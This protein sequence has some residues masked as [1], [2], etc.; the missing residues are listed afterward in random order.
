ML[1]LEEDR[2][3]ASREVDEGKEEHGRSDQIGQGA[4]QTRD[5]RCHA[6]DYQPEVRRAEPLLF[7]AEDLGEQS[8][9][10][11]RIGQPRGADGP[12]FIGSR[13]RQQRAHTDDQDDDGGQERGRTE[14]RP[15]R[16]DEGTARCAERA[17]A[18]GADDEEV[19]EEVESNH[20]HHAHEDRSRNRL[21]RLDHLIRRQGRELESRVGPEDEDERPTECGDIAGEERDEVP[22]EL[23]GL[24]RH[25]GKSSED[26]QQERRQLRDRQD[27]IDASSGLDSDEVRHQDDRDED[28]LQDRLAQVVDSRV[29]GQKVLG[30]GDRED[31]EGEPLREEETPS[32]DEPGKRTGD[33][34]HIGIGSADLRQDHHTIG[35]GEGDDHR[36][37]SCQDPHEQRR[38][39]HEPRPDRGGDIHVGPDDRADD[40]AG[41]VERVQLGRHAGLCAVTARPHRAA[42]APGLNTGLR[43]NRRRPYCVRLE[44]EDCPVAPSSPAENLATLGCPP[45]YKLVPCHG[46]N[47]IP[48]PFLPLVITKDF[49]LTKY[50]KRASRGQSFYMANSF[51]DNSEGVASTV[52]TLFALL[53]AVLFLQAALISLLPARQY[54]AERQTS[55]AA[56]QALEYL[57]YAAVGAAVPGVQFSFT[58]PLG[59]PSSSAFS[60]P[61]DGT[62]PFHTRN[63]AAA[64][65]TMQYVPTL[66]D[67]PINQ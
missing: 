46:W 52:A 37:R 33:R 20:D 27:V 58:I 48:E 40:E 9:N 41:H 50:L 49:E 28:G 36:D 47:R 57:R 42:M 30:E 25:E 18:D 62:L 1:A 6:E 24:K 35:E 19:R 21:P 55:V 60:T 2:G 23:A 22:R 29:E 4:H 31:R 12:R 13:D 66:H 3:E 17:S 43:V 7:P 11:H 16:V 67:N 56:L 39:A 65:I 64:D 5:V 54:A 14:R 38:R 44:V 15:S 10:R 8:V 45:P 61:S 26:D 34:L 32:D 51:R 63:L 53:A 59:T